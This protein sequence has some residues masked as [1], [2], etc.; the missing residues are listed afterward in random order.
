MHCKPCRNAKVLVCG[1]RSA[2]KFGMAAF[3]LGYFYRNFDGPQICSEGGEDEKD[4]YHYLNY[5]LLKLSHPA[6][7]HS[8]QLS[9]T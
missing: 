9:H 8:R 3:P 6:V 2:I 7:S 1:E 4:S 5:N